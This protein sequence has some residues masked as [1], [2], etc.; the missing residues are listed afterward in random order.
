MHADQSALTQAAGLGLLLHVNER[1]APTLAAPGTR[2]QAAG[3]IVG[4]FCEAMGW[5]C[6]TLWVRDPDEADRLA[7]MGA[8]GIGAP[9]I[10]E[11]LNYTHGRRPILHQAG[12][13]GAAWLG[14][15]PVWVADMAADATYRRVPIALRAGLHAALALPVSAGAQVLAVL[16]LYSTAAFER[17]EALCAGL[18]LIGAQIGQFLLRSQAQQQL[19]E[20]EKRFRCLTDLSSD[21]FWEQDAQG[22]FVRFE[23][24]GLTRE[25]SELA[26][27]FVG[28]RLWEVS[29][30]VPASGDWG[31]RR[32]QFERQESFRDLEAVCRDA[33]GAMVHIVFHGEPAVDGDG[34]CIGYR[35][36][37]RDVTAQKQAAQRI[38]Y[39]ST[40]DELTGL[41][42]RAALRHLVAQAIELAR[43]YERRF[44][45][46]L[47]DID[48]F[49]RIN[50]GLGRDAG[51]AL[52]RET[53]QRLRK[54][55]RS[56]DVVARLDGNAF[57]VLAHELA[58]A[59]DARLVAGKLQQAVN[60]TL[61]LQGR[62][63]R[64]TACAGVAV[65]PQHAADERALMQQASQALRAAKRLGAGSVRTG[66]ASEGRTEN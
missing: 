7:C 2:A 21:W 12:L 65:Y 22:R 38:Q 63:V 44:A 23:G 20:S 47:L 52:L 50:E 51:D 32:A 59:D 27:L 58:D 17:D 33:Q 41:P 11:F 53:A 60:E 30:L 37:A 43:R 49:E 25:G 3:R 54:A 6:G 36:T 62:A 42:N 64:V 45:L 1:L 61:R 13:V 39:L 10:H 24:H 9:G 31:A 8:W 57:A 48:H 4:A 14:G 35:G 40:H 29:G 34:R 18:P 66:D 55:L 56:S 5:A 16:E 26:P 15:T 46:L 19:A 28:Q